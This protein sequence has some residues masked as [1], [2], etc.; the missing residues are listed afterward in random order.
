MSWWSVRVFGRNQF[1]KLSLAVT[2]LHPARKRDKKTYRPNTE[3]PVRLRLVCKTSVG[4]TLVKYGRKW[5]IV[6][7]NKRHLGSWHKLH[8]ERN[9]QKQKPTD[10]SG[11]PKVKI[12]LELVWQKIDISQMWDVTPQGHVGVLYEYIDQA[13]SVDTLVDAVCYNIP[14]DHAR[15]TPTVYHISTFILYV[16]A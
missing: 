4:I 8:E 7:V 1:L 12:Q 9:S 15:Q 11:T 3:D 13:L 2:E 5:L 14:A 16:A 10:R 6:L